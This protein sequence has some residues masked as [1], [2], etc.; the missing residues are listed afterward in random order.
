VFRRLRRSAQDPAARDDG[1]AGPSGAQ[2]GG[3]AVDADQPGVV[4]SLG[5]SPD[6]ESGAPA[7]SPKSERPDGPWDISE[8]AEPRRGRLDLGALLVPAAQ[9]AQVR[10]DVDKATGR[11]VA[12]AIV[13]GESAL[14]LQA[15]AAPRSEGVW[16]EI[17]AEILA[18]ITAQHGTGEEVEGPFGTEL[19]AGVPVALPE[20]KTGLQPLRFLGVDGP[21]WFLRGVVSGRAALDPAAAGDLETLFRQVVVIRGSEARPPREPLDLALP[22]AATQASAAQGGGA[23]GGAQGGGAQ[24]GDAQG[25]D[26]QG[27]GAQGGTVGA[28][29][30]GSS[31]PAAGAEPA[32]DERPSGEA[33]A[34]P[35]LNP[36]AR[37]P[38]ITEL[39]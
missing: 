5:D 7:P 3:G 4:Q 37:G 6:A 2:E 13:L 17:R 21:R 30:S 22:S 1:P 26:A 14:Q 19:R 20:G 18:G 32:A 12:A 31:R 24:G 34:R 10:V 16:P 36:F 25:G 23:Q 8:L 27:G 35:D 9:G 29:P 33:P 11:V 39:R 15:F 28:T 38:E